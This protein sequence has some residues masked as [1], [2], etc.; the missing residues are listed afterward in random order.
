M[1]MYS[2]SYKQ[3]ETSSECWIPNEDPWFNEQFVEGRKID[4]IHHLPIRYQIDNPRRLSDYPYCS[5]W[6]LV[7]GKFAS[8]LRT[9]TSEYQ[10]LPSEIYKKDTLVADDYVSFVFTSAVS[11]L[12]IQKSV[13]RELVHGI[14]L[15][16]KKIVLSVRLLNEKSANI[17]IFRIKEYAMEIVVTEKGKKA[18]EE[19]DIR[20]VGFEELEVI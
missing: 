6:F 3:G 18:I 8:V 19:A 15:G 9:L 20:F 11:A 16:M 13:Y 14:I 10:E 1:K 17:D 7:S 4:S 12:H 5:K 2:M